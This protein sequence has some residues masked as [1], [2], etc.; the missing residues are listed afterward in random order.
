MFREN[1]G[2]TVGRARRGK[3]ITKESFNS[4]CRSTFC[5]NVLF[6][7]T[8]VWCGAS[9]CANTR[10]EFRARVTPDKGGRN[11]AEAGRI[12]LVNPDLGLVAPNWGHAPC[13][14][15][16]QTRVS[17]LGS[18][19]LSRVGAESRGVGWGARLRIWAIW[20]NSMKKG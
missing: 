16:R 14:A 2:E 3:P 13:G 8:P 4:G 1:W 7:E 20:H 9:L 18:S 12:W 17:C 10:A 15:D 19:S 5:S 6:P 11:A